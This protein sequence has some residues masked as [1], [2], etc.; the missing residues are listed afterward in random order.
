[1]APQVRKRLASTKNLDHS[2]DFR[3]E[4]IV[5]RSFGPAGLY[6]GAAGYLGD[7]LNVPSTYDRWSEATNWVSGCAN[8]IILQASTHVKICC[9]IISS[10]CVRQT[11]DRAVIN[12]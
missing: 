12:F 6:R 4:T 2:E 3:G 5:A 8:S 11:G 9:N 10:V 1:M 7:W